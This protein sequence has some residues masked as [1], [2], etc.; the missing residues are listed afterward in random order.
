MAAAS[1]AAQYEEPGGG[2]PCPFHVEP[3][4]SPRPLPMV[5]AGTAPI[6][7]VLG[8]APGG[9]SFGMAG[10]EAGCR[11]TAASP[12]DADVEE[13]AVGAPSRAGAGTDGGKDRNSAPA[14]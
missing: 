3:T 14:C 7:P 11:I 2:L 12:V 6:E 13:A 4:P 8:A 9:K 5:E 10:V 1:A